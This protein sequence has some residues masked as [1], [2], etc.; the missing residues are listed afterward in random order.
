MPVIFGSVVTLTRKP[1]LHLIPL[2]TR[3]HTAF[4]SQSSRQDCDHA[5]LIFLAFKE[6]ELTISVLHASY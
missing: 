4:V 1:Q 3:E 6:M 5:I 2:A